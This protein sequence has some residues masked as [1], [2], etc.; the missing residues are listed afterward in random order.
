V[1]LLKAMPVASSE[2]TADRSLQRRP[3]LTVLKSWPSWPRAKPLR[4][5][6]KSTEASSALRGLRTFFQV[7]PPF[8]EATMFL[9]P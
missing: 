3:P 5:V 7:R 2:P 8:V 4:V 9:D 6:T 1:A